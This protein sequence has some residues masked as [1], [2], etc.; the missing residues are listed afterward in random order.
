[1]LVNSADKG[2][3]LAVLDLV[4]CCADNLKIPDVIGLSECPFLFA[5]W[6]RPSVAYIVQLED[7]GLVA[8]DKTL[9]IF[10]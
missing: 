5:G 2:A 9:A 1:M 8:K 6:W 7:L 3:F 10:S 4:K